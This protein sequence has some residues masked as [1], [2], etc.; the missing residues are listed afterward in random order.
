[1]GRMAFILFTVSTCVA[2][3]SARADDA[4]PQGEVQIT[5]KADREQP[6]GWPLVVEVTLTN[7]GARAISWWCGGPEIYPGAEHFVVE[8][9]Y[10]PESEWHSVQPTNGQYTEGSG[11]NRELK[12]GESI[13][14][15]LAIPVS[16][17]D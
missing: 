4:R 1:M 5:A 17:A 14:V 9:R 13:V 2:I 3:A 12:P 7:S 11:G 16:K 6:T 10:G 8:V 15:P